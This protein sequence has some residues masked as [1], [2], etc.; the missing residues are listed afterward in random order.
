MSMTQPTR[1]PASPRGR[2]EGPGETPWWKRRVTW[3]VA[4]ALLIFGLGNA[5][6]GDDGGEP[7]APVRTALASA[8]RDLDHAEQARADAQADAA[9]A[10][11]AAE[12]AQATAAQAQAQLEDLE[13]QLADAEQ[14]EVDLRGELDQ[15]RAQ[16]AA[17]PPAAVVAAPVAAAPAPPPAPPAPVAAAPAPQALVPQPAAAPAPPPPPP[18][19]APASV[20]Y[21]NCDAA[22]AAG[23]APVYRG[24]PGYRPGLDRDDDGVGCES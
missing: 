6:A 23:A 21:E 2:Y 14:R 18:A 10:R 15:L 3:Y 4:A 8:N 13:Q 17:T 24:D 7:A 9:D 12:D 11:K 16:L 22:R 20:H 5:S 1:P 19:P